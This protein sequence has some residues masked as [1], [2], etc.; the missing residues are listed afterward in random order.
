MWVREM[1]SF[2]H[3]SLFIGIENRLFVPSYLRYLKEIGVRWGA[4]SISFNYEPYMCTSYNPLVADG[5]CDMGY[6]PLLSPSVHIVWMAA[7]EATIF[8]IL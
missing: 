2:R 8:Q 5:G 6:Q 4:A 1:N 7:K 3:K